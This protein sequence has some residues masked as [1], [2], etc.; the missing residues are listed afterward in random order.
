MKRRRGKKEGDR[1]DKM[2]KDKQATTLNNKNR[3]EKSIKRRG[4]KQRMRRQKRIVYNK[5]WRGKGNGI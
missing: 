2:G 4:R 3:E 5:I 1:S